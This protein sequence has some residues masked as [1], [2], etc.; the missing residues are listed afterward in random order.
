MTFIYNIKLVRMYFML[1]PI[2]SKSIDHTTYINSNGNIVPS[3]TTII[4]TINKESLLYW[5]NS[6]GFKHKSVRKELELSAYVGTMAHSLID[7][8]ISTNTYSVNK[9]TERGLAERLLIKNAFM[10]FLEFYIAE[11]KKLKY[12]YTERQ[13]SGRRFGGTLDA[14]AKY[15]GK[16]TLIDY[17]T[18][19]DFYLTMFLQI[20]GYDIL[21]RELENIKVD[22]Y[23]VILLDKKNGDTARAKIISNTDE[24][25]YYR[26]CFKKLVLFYNNWIAINQKY[27]E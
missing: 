14:L 17:K 3:V 12:I 8:Y 9:M 1:K 18:S 22:Q 7:E 11:K 5:S 16:L 27:W 15:R 10:S 19:S 24:M 25:M 4:K 20:A 6:L 2:F 23:M 26:T 13:L 21:L